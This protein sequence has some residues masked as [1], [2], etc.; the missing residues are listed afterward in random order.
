M[1]LLPGLLIIAFLTGLSACAYVKPAD[2]VNTEYDGMAKGPGI[3]TG[4]SGEWTVL[5]K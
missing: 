5:R 1:R 2:E 3:F 4:R